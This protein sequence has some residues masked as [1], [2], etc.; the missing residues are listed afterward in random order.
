MDK[1]L[2]EDT[3]LV[4]SKQYLLEVIRNV[5]LSAVQHNRMFAQPSTLHFT[6]VGDQTLIY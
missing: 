5:L 4:V 1:K 6:S 2:L 3:D